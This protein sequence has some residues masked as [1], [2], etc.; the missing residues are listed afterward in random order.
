GNHQETEL[1]CNRRAP[2]F[3]R[4]GPSIY[5][6]S[7]TLCPLFR[8]VFSFLI[9]CPLSPKEGNNQPFSEA[10]DNRLQGFVRGFFD[11][12]PTFPRQVLLYAAVLPR[13]FSKGYCI[14][15]IPE[16]RYPC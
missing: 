10:T 13:V 1:P 16:L 6:H 3:G 5:S 4:I 2:G 8:L 15:K 14:K 12:S 11:V 9:G 7:S